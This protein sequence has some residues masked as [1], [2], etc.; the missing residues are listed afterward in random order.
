M[1]DIS[2]KNLFSFSQ[3]NSFQIYRYLQSSLSLYM[4]DMFIS[5]IILIKQGNITDCVNN[6]F[7][8]IQS[9]VLNFPGKSP[10]KRCNSAKN[11]KVCY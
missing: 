11:M 9:R 4:W 8:F 5:M 2:D 6:L 7:R 3:A 1:I 10:A